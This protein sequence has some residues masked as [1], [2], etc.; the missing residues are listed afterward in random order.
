MI[1]TIII[2]MSWQAGREFRA[3]I[4]DST[5]VLQYGGVKNIIMLEPWQYYSIANKDKSFTAASCDARPPN[6]KCFRTIVVFDI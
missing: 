2:V 1:C 4:D 3:R 6:A 5:I